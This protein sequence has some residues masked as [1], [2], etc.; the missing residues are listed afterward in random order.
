MSI[1]KED[2]EAVLDLIRPN[3]EADGGNVSLID[4][5]DEGVV[6]VELEGACKGCPMSQMTLTNGVERI[7][8]ERIPEVTKVV[9][10]NPL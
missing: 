4:V 2:V 6:T 3:L 8:K 1:K 5:N 10:A 7:L 9:P